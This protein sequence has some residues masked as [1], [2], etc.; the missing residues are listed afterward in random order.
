[1]YLKNNVNHVY[2]G[3]IFIFLLADRTYV[4]IFLIQKRETMHRH[5]SS[6]SNNRV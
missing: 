2:L 6:Q 3:G 4:K 5:K 1:M